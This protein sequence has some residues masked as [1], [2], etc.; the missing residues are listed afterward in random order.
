MQ[1]GMGPQAG[2]T[3]QPTLAPVKKDLNS[4]TSMAVDQEEDVIDDDV[5][6]GEVDFEM[7]PAEKD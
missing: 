4:H 1:S 5:A 3:L 2:L 6:C 7:L